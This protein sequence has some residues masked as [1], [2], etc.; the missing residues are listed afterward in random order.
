MKRLRMTTGLGGPDY[1][2][3][4]GDE[5]DFSNEEADRLIKAG[6][7]VEVEDPQAAEKEA[8]EKEA[9]EKVSTKTAAKKS[10]TKD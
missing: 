6:F 4:R 9:A 2:L 5:H 10:A 1:N 8:A 3:T 7:G